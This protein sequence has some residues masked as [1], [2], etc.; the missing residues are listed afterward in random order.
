[1]K[2][3]LFLLSALALLALAQTAFAQAD[4]LWAPPEPNKAERDW[5]QLTSGEWLWGDIE[6]FQ[7]PNFTFDSEELDGLT[8]ELGD[9]A[10]VRSARI[11]T[12]TF[13]DDR[14]VTGTAVMQ[15]GVVRVRDAGGTVHEYPRLELLKVIE[16]DM[17]EI[18]FWSMK[19][20]LGSTI[21]TGNTNQNDLN[22]AVKIR[23]EATKSRIDLDYNGNYSEVEDT[24][25]V[26]NTRVGANWNI[27]ITRGFYVSPLLGEI[28]S[29]EF[30]NIDVRGTIG[31]GLGVFV[32]RNSTIEWSFQLGGAYRNT[33]YV[34]VEPGEPTF[35]TTGSVI[36]GT[37]VEWDITGDIDLDFNYNTQ[38]G[39]PDTKDTTHHAQ[40]YFSMDLIGDTI[41]LTANFTWDRVENPVTNADGVTPERDDFRLAFGI[42]VDL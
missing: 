11:L 32:V 13:T 26:N 23:R 21:R 30:Q 34:S 18:N 25:T 14:V 33:Q 36:P 20:S 28:Y 9:I 22:T 35:N 6:L 40:A 7:E 5:I 37:V 31:A 42:G 41:D 16:G 1:M 12:W 4:S 19:A 2:R 3:V 24:A 15:K 27:V 39:V 8:I 17:S 38:I 29:D 10:V